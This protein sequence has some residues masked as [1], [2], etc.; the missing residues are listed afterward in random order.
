MLRDLPGLWPRGETDQPSIPSSNKAAFK[1]AQK[2]AQAKALKK[3]LD[4]QKKFAGTLDP[5]TDM[6][7]AEE[8]QCII[9]RCSGNGPVG[10]I[11]LVQRSRLISLRNRGETSKMGRYVRVVGDKGCQVRAT[12]ALDSVPLAFLPV[13]SVVEMVGYQSQDPSQCQDCDD[14]D[15]TLKSRRVKVRVSKN[16][17]GWASVSSVT[18]YVILA[19]LMDHCHGRWGTTRP[20][21]HLCGHTAHISCVEAHCLSL[22]QKATDDQPYDGRF[23]ANIQEGEFLCPLCKQLSNVVIPKVDA[24][25]DT[26]SPVDVDVTSDSKGAEVTLPSTRGMLHSLTRGVM[27]STRHERSPAEEDANGR[28]GDG[29]LQAM[30]PV[31]ENPDG[32]RNH[33]YHSSI[34]LKWDYDEPIDGGIYRDVLRNLRTMHI[35][36]SALGYKV[37]SAEAS[38]R[39]EHCDDPWNGY[40][41]K[42]RDTH[43]ENT[44]LVR[45]ILSTVEL[46]LYLNKKIS[47]SPSG[48]DKGLALIPTLLGQHLRPKPHAAPTNNRKIVTS[49]IASLPCHISRDLQL[50]HRHIARAAATGR[51]IAEGSSPTPL[52]VRK[53][54]LYTKTLSGCYNDASKCLNGAYFRPGIASGFLYVPTL[55]WD[56]N[57]LAAAVLSTLIADQN[58]T[59][60]EVLEATHS[61]L[62]ARLIQAAVTPK[63]FVME[64][65]ENESDYDWD[66]VILTQESTALRELL[67][68]IYGKVRGW[69]Q[70][71][72]VTP[73]DDLKFMRAVGFA[74]LPFARALVL[75]LRGLSAILRAR[76]IN[77]E[78]ISIFLDDF[79]TMFVADGLQLACMIMGMPLP[80]VLVENAQWSKTIDIWV[81][82]VVF[83]E[84]HH[85]SRGQTVQ[86]R[87][88]DWKP[89]YYE[90]KDNCK[91][92]IMEADEIGSGV[93]IAAA[94]QLGVGLVDSM[95]GSSCLF[96]EDY[97]DAHAAAQQGFEGNIMN[98]ASVSMDPED[99]A[100]EDD[101]E[102]E[103]NDDMMVDMS[104]SIN[105]D[106]TANSNAEASDEE[107]DAEAEVGSEDQLRPSRPGRDGSLTLVNNGSI[108]SVSV[109]DLGDD[110]LRRMDKEHASV[111]RGGMIPFQPSLL[112]REMVG[113]GPRQQVLDMKA[114]S[115]VMCDLS[116][117]GMLHRPGLSSSGL[118]RLPKSFVELYGLVNSIMGTGQEESDELANGETAICLL[119]GA[120]MRSGAARRPYAR[121]SSQP[122]ACTVH[123]RKVGSGVGI[124]FLI[125]KCTILLVHN[126]KSAYSA[127]LYVDEN[128]EEDPGL[129]R[130]RPL[131]LKETRYE[132]LEK[133]WR[134]H[135]CPREVAQIRSTSER[136]IRDNWY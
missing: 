87:D 5:S 72:A 82:D 123:A 7:E 35:G 28:Y 65:G 71:K 105:F 114:A 24:K 76:G 96:G 111:M 11:G 132:A 68:T 88:L 113:V 89:S 20:V 49:I 36:W 50:H 127:S 64:D 79:D 27:V 55:A 136:V 30:Q 23:A 119:T 133:L 95:D 39:M 106:G 63:G 47:A 13:G 48:S 85:G 115:K 46:F 16:V 107:M 121:D 124:F 77:T 53:L 130:G 25:P 91:T 42:R 90:E 29:L 12:E 41:A 10:S 4:L 120:V 117:L 18:G 6:E 122:G 70:A 94:S 109:N 83:L 9:C 84:S 17:T 43:T 31:W 22:H 126:N 61:L 100:M 108:G 128:G 112:G 135:G 73:T 57:T 104:M 134:S 3:M 66:P 74:I 2:A 1:A 103:S 37:S 110:G 21:V 44:E 38:A 99:D 97:N 129:R 131:F 26:K 34:L 93:E 52:A 32:Q 14:V 19:P 33:P 75:L 59:C 58:I 62:V 8:D 54:K 86:G 40:D 45:L 69:D 92:V 116:H 118:I 56:L 78:T 60:D 101:G 51:W 81:R 98:Q 125:S 15:Y 80:S 67:G 102:E